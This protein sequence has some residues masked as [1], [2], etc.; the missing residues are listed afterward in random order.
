MRSSGS[1]QW[2]SY[3]RDFQLEREVRSI[4]DLDGVKK[5]GRKLMDFLSTSFLSVVRSFACYWYSPVNYQSVPVESTT[6][7]TVGI[8]TIND[9]IRESALPT[10]K[11]LQKTRDPIIDGPITKAVALFLSVFQ[12]TFFIQ[13]VMSSFRVSFLCLWNDKCMSTCLNPT[14]CTLILHKILPLPSTKL[15]RIDSKLL[16]LPSSRSTPQDVIDP[17]QSF[18]QLQNHLES[19]PTDSTRRKT[20]RG[21]RQRYNWHTSESSRQLH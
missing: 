3:W 21:T 1:F 15:P 14:P 10:D 18:H 9:L 7:C 19:N 4:V 5:E 20:K 17:K 13:G 2:D 6:A 11:Q 12:S 8:W 16:P